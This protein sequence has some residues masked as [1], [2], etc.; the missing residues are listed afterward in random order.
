MTILQ[1]GP[2][3][4]DVE[5]KGCVRNRDF[6]PISRFVSKWYNTNPYLL[7]KATR[8]LP[9]LSKGAIFNDLE[10]PLTQTSRLRYYLTLNNSKM[11]QDTVILI[12]ADQYSKPKSY[13]YRAV[14]LLQPWTN[15]KVTPLFVADY[16]RNYLRYGH[17]CYRRRIGNRTHFQ[18]PIRPLFPI[19]S[20]AIIWCWTSQKR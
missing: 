11:V 19:T 16:L 8:K 1:R 13:I 4:G 20:Q 7:W 10:W 3:N 9:K 18:R 5:C 12:T 6:R 2:P 15:F 14:P 17:S